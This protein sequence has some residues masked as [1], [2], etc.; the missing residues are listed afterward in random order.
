MYSTVDRCVRKPVTKMDEE[1]CLS[2]E[3]V[4][5]GD[6]NIVKDL[7]NACEK[8]DIKKVRTLMQ[9]L[10]RLSNSLKLTHKPPIFWACKAGQYNTVVTLVEEFDC[11][12]HYVSERGH[13]LVH[14][15]CARGHVDVT[16]YLAK[17]HLVDPN[18]ANKDGTT[19]LLSACNNGHMQVILVLIDELKCDPHAL[20][21]NGKTLLHIACRNGHMDI[22]RL[23]VKKYKL[24]PNAVDSFRETPL[25]IACSKGHLEIVKYFADELKCPVEAFDRCSTTPLHNACRNG[26]VDIVQHLVDNHK[27]NMLLYDNSGFMP[28]HVACRY[29]RKYVIEMLLDRGFDPNTPTLSSEAPIQIVRDKDTTTVLIQR[30]AKTQGTD[31]D[32]LRHFQIQ[33]PLDSLVHVLVIGHEGAGKS[34]IVKALKT[35]VRTTD[36]LSRLFRSDVIAGDSQERTQGIVPTCFHS[37]EFGN[38]MIYDFAG[39]YDYHPSHAA[40]MEH[41]NTSSAPLFLLVVNLAELLEVNKR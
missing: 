9:C 20:G 14:V 38:L 25:H 21:E 31:L 8:G 17:Q 7:N 37:P 16:R 12:P 34:T 24:D 10:P 6:D 1:K 40:V 39:Q 36:F 23:L 13:T 41:S 19:P 30:G 27:C 4:H 28:F 5:V 3:F 11:N 35:P 18:K 32:I 22:V 26:Q 33:Q 2:S 29:G 15:S